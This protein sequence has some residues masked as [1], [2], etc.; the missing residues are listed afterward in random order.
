[1]NG[2]ERRDPAPSGD[3]QHALVPIDP[4]EVLYHGTVERF[5]TSIRTQGLRPKRRSH[6]HL[7]ASEA[8]ARRVGGRRD[9]AIVLKVEAARMAAAGFEFF[10]TESGVWLVDHVPR[11]FLLFPRGAVRRP[12]P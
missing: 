11:A 3:A 7:A 2:D 6:V 1:L 10:R 5:L 12:R 4:P 8:L 9:E